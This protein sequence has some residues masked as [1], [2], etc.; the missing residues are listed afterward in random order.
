MTKRMVTETSGHPTDRNTR[1]NGRT[2]NATE[3]ERII[4]HTVSSTTENGST[5]NTMVMVV[6]PIRMDLSGTMENGN[7]TTTTTTTTTK[8]Q[9]LQLFTMIVNISKKQKS[10]LCFW[11]SSWV[12]RITQRVM[13]LTSAVWLSPALGVLCVIVQGI[14]LSVHPVD[15]KNWYLFSSLGS[16]QFGQEGFFPV[17]LRMLF[18]WLLFPRNYKC[19]S[20]SC[21]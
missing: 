16:P 10:Y 9:Q 7:P 8:Q 12:C 20:T 1:E 11:L 6:G 13:S 3:E 2:T 17:F 14:S 21:W 5:I 19:Q 15:Q 4:T 18:L